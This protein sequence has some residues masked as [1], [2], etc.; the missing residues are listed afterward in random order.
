MLKIFVYHYY[1]EVIVSKQ[2]EI[3]IE[4]STIEERY[5][6]YKWMILLFESLQFNLNIYELELNDINR[7]K[8]SNSIE[9][10]ECV[11]AEYL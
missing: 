6:I 11:I 3:P 2:K 9:K 10:I 7:N 1:N 4:G 5:E 8:L